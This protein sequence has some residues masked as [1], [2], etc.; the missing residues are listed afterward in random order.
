MSGGRLLHRHGWS[1]Q[2]PVRRALDW[3]RPGS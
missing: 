2:M 3:S 1:V